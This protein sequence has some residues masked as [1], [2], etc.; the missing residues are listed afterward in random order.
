MPKVDYWNIREKLKEILEG[1]SSLNGVNIEIE[2]NTLIASENCPWLNIKM[3]G[4]VAED[5]EQVIA[6][7]QKTKFIVSMMID[8]KEY[9]RESPQE[10]IRLRDD[11]IGK[12]EVVL[13]KNRTLAGAID[14]LWILGGDMDQADTEKG[15]VSTGDIS[16]NMRVTATTAA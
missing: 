4:R 16:I 2:R 1:D 8:A 14:Y 7:G 13:M 9:S 3:T 6:S 12:V 11:L 10:A 5:D 15:Y